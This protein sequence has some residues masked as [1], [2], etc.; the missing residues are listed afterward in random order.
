MVHFFCELIEMLATLD[1]HILVSN[2]TRKDWVARSLA[3]VRDAISRADYPINTWF[4]LGDI[5]LLTIGFIVEQIGMGASAIDTYWND[6][7]VQVDIRRKGE[8]ISGGCTFGPFMM[9]AD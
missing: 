5:T 9:G 1:V 8:G 7:V 3:S 6:M 2:N 4:D